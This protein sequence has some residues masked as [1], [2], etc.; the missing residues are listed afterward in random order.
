MRNSLNVKIGRLLHQLSSR[1][2]IALS[3][4]VSLFKTAC[5]EQCSLNKRDCDALIHI[6]VKI[7]LVK[8]NFMFTG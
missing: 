2:H 8:S 7:F 5:L 4:S 6:Y 1:A 3:P